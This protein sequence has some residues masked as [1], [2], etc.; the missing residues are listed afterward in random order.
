MIPGK[1]GKE[2]SQA[3]SRIKSTVRGQKT[4]MVRKAG[5]GNRKK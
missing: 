4:E 3:T 5:N 1:K 2:S